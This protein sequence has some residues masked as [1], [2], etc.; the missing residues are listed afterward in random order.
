M[1]HPQLQLETQKKQLVKYVDCSIMIPEKRNQL[2][3]YCVQTVHAAIFEHSN[4]QSNIKD[5]II[6]LHV[7]MYAENKPTDKTFYVPLP[8]KLFFNR[9]NEP[10]LHLRETDGSK[11]FK[12]HS[13]FK[14]TW[15][16]ITATCIKNPKLEGNSFAEQFNNAMNK[17][18]EDPG[19]PWVDME[20]KDELE[21]TGIIRKTAVVQ[22]PRIVLSPHGPLFAYIECILFEHGPNGCPDE[23]TFIQSIIDEKIVP[24]RSPLILTAS[25]KE[26]PITH[27]SYFRSLRNRELTGSFGKNI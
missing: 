21:D 1:E 3:A 2:V 16:E 19:T 8:A 10:I 11:L 18:Y 23:K 24:L 15:L 17:F 7:Q 12:S 4:L 13:V 5:P 27:K 20:H 26:V 9:I 14:K 6:Y 22:I 25:E